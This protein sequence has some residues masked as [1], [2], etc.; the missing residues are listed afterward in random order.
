MKR[1][2]SI[3]MLLVLS[4]MLIG[5]DKKVRKQPDEWALYYAE[6]EYENVH[7]SDEVFGYNIDRM[8]IRYDDELREYRTENNLTCYLYE[9]TIIDES[10][11][12][13]IYNVFIS[14]QAPSLSFEDNV[15][16]EDVYFVDIE[17]AQ[18]EQ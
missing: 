5:C 11:R 2:L 8:A 9:I 6:L 18:N 1:I 13:H 12:S 14:I 17:E 15:I 3:M 4:I 7:G 10:G 16:E